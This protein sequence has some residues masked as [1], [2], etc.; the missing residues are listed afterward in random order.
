MFRTEMYQ[1]ED[2]FSSY[3]YLYRRAI[4]QFEITRLLSSRIVETR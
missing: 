2:V 3:L 4:E 1:V